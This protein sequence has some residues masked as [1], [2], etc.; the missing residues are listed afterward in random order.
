MKSYDRA[1]RCGRNYA[2]AHCNRGAAMRRSAATPKRWR[3]STS[4]LSIEPDFPG[5]D[6][7]PLRRL[8]GLNRV[9]EAMAG[10]EKLIAS[11]PGYAEAH[12]TT[13]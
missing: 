12:Y 5:G 8:R 11:N 1:W 4:A 6:A 2:K 10:L 9:D 13:A 3:V 7:Q